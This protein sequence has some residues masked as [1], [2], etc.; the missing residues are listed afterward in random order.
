[1]ATNDPDLP[2]QES[3]NPLL[4]ALHAS[5]CRMVAWLRRPNAGWLRVPLAPRLIVGGLLSFLPIHDI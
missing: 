5:E 4:S 3:S 1:M 2:D